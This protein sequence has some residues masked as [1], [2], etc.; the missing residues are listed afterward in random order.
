MPAAARATAAIVEIPAASAVQLEVLGLHP[1]LALDYGAFRWLWLEAGDQA[2]LA[3]SG[4]TFW[5]RSETRE[6]HLPGRRFDP[7]APGAAAAWPAERGFALVQLAG[8]VKPEWLRS[9][10]KAGLAPLQYYPYW[11]YLVWSERS[12]SLAAA[13]RLPF[14]RAIVGLAAEDRIASRLAAAAGPIRNLSL[15]VYPDGRLSAVQERIRA[16]GAKILDVFPAQPD[17]GFQQLIAEA[18]SRALA[19]LAA[20]PE[21]LWLGWSSPRPELEDEV[22]DQIVA[23]NHSDGN[24]LPGY[25][26]FLGSLGLDGSGVLWAITDS[27]IDYDHP[28]VG[29]KIVG[30]RSFPGCETALPGDALTNGHGTHLAGILAGTAATGLRDEHGFLWGQGIA[31]GASLFAQNPLCLTQ[32]SWPPAGGWAEL[33]RAPAE[34]GALG[35]NNSWQTGEGAAHGYQE[36]ERTHDFLVRDADFEDGAE[37]EA[38]ILV[39]A[40]GNYGTDGL[41]A[42]KEAKNLIV[43]ANSY[44]SRAGSIDQ[45]YSTSS[46]G[47]TLDGRIVPTVA[48]PGTQV[49]SARAD[50]ASANCGAAAIPGTGGLYA[51]CSGTSMAAPHVAGA[52]ALLAQQWRASHGGA[53]P[54]PALAKARLVASAE[55]LGQRDVPNGAE[56]WGRVSLPDLLAPTVPVLAFDQEQALTATGQSWS[57]T[58]LVQDPAKPLKVSLA[59]T[60]VPGAIGANPALVNDLDLRVETGGTSY[61]GNQ[62]LGGHS[63]AGGSPDRRDNLENVF[64]DQPGATVHVTVT[65][66]HLAADALH[67]RRGVTEQDFALVCSNCS[68]AANSIFGD[69]FESGNTSAWGQTVP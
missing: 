56:G 18:D 13:S 7:L 8:P 66:A 67:A 35:S 15:T 63:V 5:D 12:E 36:S 68:M 61:L 20:L 1:L 40:A 54:S 49:A 51:F 58:A 33:T 4:L 25:S 50:T 14:V 55:D 42:P 24:P 59:W 17:G 28:D 16:T 2:R 41:T 31:P 22:T 10:G 38:F 57:F 37:A 65:A 39:F 52:I 3:A 6:L 30:G 69:G 48:A 9:L 60:D 11:S 53:D 46:R 29:S 34:A 43:A 47:P 23:G 45:I 64:V 21:V 26:A 44:S 62:F 32:T 19:G 27:G